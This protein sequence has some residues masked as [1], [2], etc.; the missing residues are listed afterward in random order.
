MAEQPGPLDVIVA[1][2]RMSMTPLLVRIENRD[3]ESA[4]WLPQISVEMGS[5]LEPPCVMVLEWYRYNPCM[6]L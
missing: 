1:R 5:S 6:K 3:L 2:G 4:L